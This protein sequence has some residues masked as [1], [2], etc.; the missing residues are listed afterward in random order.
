[1]L[2]LLSLL[3]II[4]Y[5]LLLRQTDAFRVMQWR[6]VLYS[7]AYGMACA[8]ILWA[9]SLCWKALHNGQGWQA[10]WISPVIEEI[11]KAL[12]FIYFIRKHRMA[13]LCETVIYGASVGGGFALVENILYIQLCPDMALGTAII[14]GFGTAL[15]HMGCTSLIAS[16][17]LVLNK[18]WQLLSLIPSIIIHWLHNLQPFSPF[19]Q[20][21]VVLVVFLIIFM[22]IDVLDNRRITRWL[23]VSLS[24]DVSLLAS[25][26]RGELSSTKAGI[27]LKDIGIHFEREVFFDM[28]MYVRLYLEL[29]LAAKSRLMLRESGLEMPETEEQR[30]IH[31]ANVEELRQLR[32]RIPLLGRRLLMPIVHET[33]ANEWVLISKL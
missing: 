33:A 21:F 8:A 19:V 6:R 11:L 29:S 3:P 18:H 27:Y 7:I 16:L 32:L 28:I 22:A 20:L 24:D 10:T 5:L 14:R 26:R 9:F 31:E 23:D 2:Y 15:L 30:K 1:M 12:I 25:I 17:A 13:F 4:C